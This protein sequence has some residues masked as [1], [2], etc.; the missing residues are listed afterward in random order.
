MIIT[1]LSTVATAAMQGPSNAALIAVP[2]YRTTPPV[3]RDLSC[4]A[5]S[6]H[7]RN[8]SVSVELFRHGCI[9]PL[10]V[11]TVFI[12]EQISQGADLSALMDP[13]NPTSLMAEY[14]DAQGYQFPWGYIVESAAAEGSAAFVQAHIAWRF[15][16]VQ[17]WSEHFGVKDGPA[18][19]DRLRAFAEAVNVS[20][21]RCL[22]D[23]VLPAQ[24][25][26][27]DLFALTC[28]AADHDRARRWLADKLLPKILPRLLALVECNTC[29]PGRWV[30]PSTPALSH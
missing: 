23:Y 28:L 14:L 13:H 3:R 16:P 21:V 24:R 9:Q 29:L 15:V 4:P 26:P 30:I 11:P 17:F 20:V 19:A 8:R 22:P 1:D 6:L 7:W 12:L 2:Q 27:H 5:K 25:R 18:I 10:Q